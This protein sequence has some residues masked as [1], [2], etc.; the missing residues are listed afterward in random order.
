MKEKKEKTLIEKVKSLLMN[1]EPVKDE[2]SLEELP[3]IDGS[4][5]F[6]ESFSAGEAVFMVTGEGERIPLPI[7]EYELEDGRV[8]IVVSEGLIDEI[9][10]AAP[11]EEAPAP[12]AEPE[13]T[14]ETQAEMSTEESEVLDQLSNKLSELTELSKNTEK[15]KA[16][17]EKRASEGIKASPEG[18]VQRVEFSKPKSLMSQKERISLAMQNT[19]FATKLATTTSVTTTYAGESAGQYIAAATL[20]GATLG[21]NAITIKPNVKYKTVVKKLAVSSIMADRTCDFTDT[22][23]VTL[24]E[25]ILTPKELQVN[26]ELCKKDFRSDWEAVEMGYSAWDNM[27]PNFEAFLTEHVA[28]LVNESIETSIW[29]GVAA[30]SGQ[31]GGYVP[32]MTA[33]G[34]VV[35]VTGTTVTAANVITELGKVVDAIPSKIRMSEDMIIYVAQNVASAYIRALGGFGTSG[36]GANGYDNKGTA[37]YNNGQLMF[38]GIPIFVAKGMNSN[39][40]VAAEKSNLWYGTGLL[41]DANMVKI[42]DMEDND[43]SE[44]V[45][46]ILKFTAGVQYGIGA[47]IVLYTPA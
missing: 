7:G 31:F 44:N 9:T 30:T 34:D 14:E 1:D 12:A 21:S 2:I 46:Y 11:Q 16:E 22:G 40:M 42:L 10:E 39:Y 29:H 26:L 43:G 18:K 33:D 13:M 19:P 35:D 20:Q 47:E 28:A 8:L 27:P 3:L 38:D 24:T 32:L 25:R 4:K 36:L 37:W 17:L 6:A 41:D 23:S 15:M 5:L 45:R